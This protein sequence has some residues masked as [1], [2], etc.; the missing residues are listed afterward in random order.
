MQFKFIAASVAALS[1]GSAIAGPVPAPVSENG[2][3]AREAA[4]IAQPEAAPAA[5]KARDIDGDELGSIHSQAWTYAQQKQGE[6]PSDYDLTKAR[7]YFPSDC[8]SNN[9]WSINDYQTIGWTAQVWYIYILYAQY[10]TYSYKWD[11]YWP[12]NWNQWST[13]CTPGLYCTGS[14]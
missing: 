5:L 2:I 13:Y 7:Q 10:N 1:V 3:V 12:T 9:Y 11:T 6:K 14:H 8:W 4:A